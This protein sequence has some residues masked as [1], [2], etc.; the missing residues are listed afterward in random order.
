[1]SK[2]LDKWALD[3]KHSKIEHIVDTLISKDII[4]PEEAKQF[5]IA[6]DKAIILGHPIKIGGEKII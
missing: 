1:M 3:Q 2:L 6:L 5:K 4:K